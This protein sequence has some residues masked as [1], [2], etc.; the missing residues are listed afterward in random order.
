MDGMYGVR[1]HHTVCVCVRVCNGKILP[2]D[3]IAVNR[4]LKKNNGSEQMRNAWQKSNCIT[5]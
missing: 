3:S 1:S 2:Y 4:E 5:H